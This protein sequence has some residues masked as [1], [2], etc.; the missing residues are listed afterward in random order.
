MTTRPAASLVL[1][2]RVKRGDHATGHEHEAVN[3]FGARLEPHCVD[4]TI[5]ETDMR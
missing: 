5:I 2:V 1:Q 3:H 4:E